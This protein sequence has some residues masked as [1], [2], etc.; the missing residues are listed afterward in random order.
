[1]D[2]LIFLGFFAIS[3]GFGVSLFIRGLSSLWKKHLI[4]T[5]PTSKI[6][7]LAM[8]RVEVLGEVVAA[9]D[10]ILKSPLEHKSCVYYEF[11]IEEYK[12]SGK[13]ERWHVIDS[14]SEST[15]FFLKDETGSVLVEP[16]GAQIDIQPYYTCRSGPGRIIP[17][18]VKGY[19][20]RND[21]PYKPKIFLS[22]ELRFTEFII[23]PK[24][25]LYIMGCAGDNPFV[26]EAVA[27]SNVEDIMIQQ[28]GTGK[29]YFISDKPEREV[30]KKLKWDWVGGILGGSALII[31]SLVGFVL[32]SNAL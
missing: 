27:K 31:V 10:K 26:E 11:I 13:N 5:T 3:M 19:M 18:A 7:S 8:G 1:M 30:L 29:I 28:G 24:D 21:F 2:V 9:K 32:F 14:F 4:E 6:R 16:L 22:G 15:Y 25:K 17:D 20:T 12:Y 23:Q